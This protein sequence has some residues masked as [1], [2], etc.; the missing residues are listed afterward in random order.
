MKLQLPAP[1]QRG[2]MTILFVLLMLLTA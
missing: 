1:L 2:M